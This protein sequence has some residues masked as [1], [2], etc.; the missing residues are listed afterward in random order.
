MLTGL[1]ELLLILLILFI[2][3][4]FLVVFVFYVSMLYDNVH[5][6]LEQS[7]QLVWLLLQLLFGVIVSIIYYFIV[8]RKDPHPVRLKGKRKYIALVLSI[9]LGMVGIDRLYLWQRWLWLL[10][11]MTLGGLFIWWIVDIILIATDVLKP[12]KGWLKS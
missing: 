4:F 8:Y 12:T 11:L 1:Q 3:L 6:K 2:F 9:F 10:K 7:E 5:R